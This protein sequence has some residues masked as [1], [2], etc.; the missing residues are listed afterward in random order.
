MIYETGIRRAG[1][2]AKPLVDTLNVEI[3][4]Y[5]RADIAGFV[6]KLRS[7]HAQ[8]RVLIVTQ[9]LRISRW[10]KDM[11]RLAD[12][13]IARAAEY[14]DLVRDHYWQWARPH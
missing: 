12:I 11:G 1:E 8:D 14:D 5:P 7:Q 6:G 9:S 13:T 4:T 2:T 3:K 10:L